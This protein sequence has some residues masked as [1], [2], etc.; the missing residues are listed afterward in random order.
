MPEK[1]EKTD[2]DVQREAYVTALRRERAGYVQ[3]G[4]KDRVEAVD[5]ELKR[6]GAAE[7]RVQS[8]PRETTVES[9]PRRTAG[10]GKQGD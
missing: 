4:L 9:K 5:A 8:A 7:E 1:E 10:R 2:E 6:L 3:R